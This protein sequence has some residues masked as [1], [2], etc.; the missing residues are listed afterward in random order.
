MAE[1]EMTVIG[2]IRLDKVRVRT[3]ESGVTLFEE[4]RNGCITGLNWA[5]CS[6]KFH[7]IQA[8]LPGLRPIWLDS[9]KSHSIQVNLTGF[10]VQAN[11]T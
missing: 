8:N 11:L 5:Q 4:A 1:T 2:S 7:S 9:G 3:R 6:G 10:N